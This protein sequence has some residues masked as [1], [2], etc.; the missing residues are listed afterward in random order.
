MEYGYQCWKF[1]KSVYVYFVDLEKVFDNVIQCNLWVFQEYWVWSPLLMAVQSLYER[2][3]RLVCIASSRSD[4]FPM[5]AK[6]QQG[7]PVGTE[8]Q[9]MGT[10]MKCRF[11]VDDVVML[12]SPSQVL[13]QFADKCEAARRGISASKSTAMIVG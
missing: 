5:C 4:F 12:V 6:V 11:Y 13:R 2:S 10:K 3:R 7:C 8:S 1:A 9:G